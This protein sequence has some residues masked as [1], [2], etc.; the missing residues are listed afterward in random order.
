MRVRSQLGESVREIDG[1]IRDWLIMLWMED[2]V[3]FFV[4]CIKVEAIVR[5][6][7]YKKRP[8][9]RTLR[10]ES[11]KTDGADK[12]L[13]DGH[14]NQDDYDD[15]GKESKGNKKKVKV[16]KID[17]ADKHL[18]DGQSQPSPGSAHCCSNLDNDDDYDYN[19]RK[20]IIM[21]KMTKMTIMI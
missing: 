6:R 11:E 16:K 10:S 17:G 21:I 19:H 8:N 15:R 9:T 13:H 18:H 5:S 1:E 2:N 4:L 14:D 12:Q 3:S 20:I 7:A